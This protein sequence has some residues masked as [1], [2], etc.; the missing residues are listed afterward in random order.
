MLTSF[1]ERGVKML[2]VADMGGGGVKNG[3]KSDGVLYGRSQI[4][5]KLEGI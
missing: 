1:L 2:T 5:S 3:Q 4:E